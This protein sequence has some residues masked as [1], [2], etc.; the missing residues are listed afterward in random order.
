MM[1]EDK[2]T[3]IIRS[4]DSTSVKSPGELLLTILCVDLTAFFPAIAV[5]R[6]RFKSMEDSDYSP[7]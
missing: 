7:A 1:V 3:P 2:E 4:I 6:L 5:A